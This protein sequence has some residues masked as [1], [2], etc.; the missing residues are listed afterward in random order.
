MSTLSRRMS[1]VKKK[2][3]PLRLSW[4]EYEALS[5]SCLSSVLLVHPFCRVLFASSP[6]LHIL[7]VCFLINVPVL[8]MSLPCKLPLLCFLHLYRFFFRVLQIFLSLNLVHIIIL[9]YLLFFY[10]YC[11]AVHVCFRPFLVYLTRFFFLFPLQLTFPL[12]VS[13]HWK[14]LC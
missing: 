8:L 3:T 4:P 12:C 13:S 14:L 1:F 2:I 10:L 11:M 5:R 9:E 6:L 7:L